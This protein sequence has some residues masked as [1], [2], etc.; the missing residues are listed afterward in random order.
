MKQLDE[1]KNLY[2]DIKSG[3]IAPVYLLMGEETYFI[4]KISEEL[5]KNILSE[6]EKA[7]NQHVVYGKD[8]DMD[9]VVSLAKQFPMGAER[10]VIMV[11]EAQELARTIDKL[12]AYVKQPQPSTVLILCYKYKSV[13]KRKAVYKAI[14]KSGVVFESKKLYENEVPNW[15][16]RVARGKHLLIDP[17]SAQLMVEYLGTDLGKIS[18]ELDKLVLALPKGSQIS[19]EHIERYVGISKNYNN[20]EL[21]KAL[22]NRDV[23]RTNQ[24][25]KYFGNN[26]KDHPTVV[27][28]SVLYNFFT[29]L[30]TYHVSKDKT[31]AGVA[32]A[33]KINP[34][35]VKDYQQAAGRYSLKQSFKVVDYLREADMKSKG[36]GV[37]NMPED[38]LLK[39]LCFKILHVY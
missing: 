37:S 10:Q 30:I 11:R 31:K 21:Q 22:G 16:I 8:V 12:E 14:K 27:T 38:Q 20:F 2:A 24:I 9:Q 4:D 29:K 32:S 5:E 13:D 1:V 7:F 23:F 15:L 18:K 33:L 6:D 25:I 26:P 39:E 17:V 34:F 19:S 36:V 28:I 3:K 35:F